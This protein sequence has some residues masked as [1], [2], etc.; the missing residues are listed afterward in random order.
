M[1][2]LTVLTILKFWEQME[3]L[4]HSPFGIVP[5]G[6]RKARAPSRRLRPMVRE[7]HTS[8]LTPREERIP[9]DLFGKATFTWF[10]L[11]I[12]YL[13]ILLLPRP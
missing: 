5:R 11:F 13:Y 2:E 3:K 8:K 12:T 1:H 6:D 4:R 7:V 10:S 9:A